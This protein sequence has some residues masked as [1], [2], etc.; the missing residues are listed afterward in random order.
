MTG[1]EVA[2]IIVVSARDATSASN[3]VAPSTT[4][5]GTPELVCRTGSTS[6]RSVNARSAR[7]AKVRGTDASSAPRLARSPTTVTST[8]AVTRVPPCTSAAWP[9]KR[10]QG[11][12]SP[13]SH[14]AR[15]A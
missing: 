13:S 10:N 7:R 6:V 5:T 14:A 9:P 4:S 8:S 3:L 11:Q 15:S 2:A 12:P 1:I